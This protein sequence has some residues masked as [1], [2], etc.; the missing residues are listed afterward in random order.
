MQLPLEYLQSYVHLY[1][2][3]PIESHL[4]PNMLEKKSLMWIPIKFLIKTKCGQYISSLF[5]LPLESFLILTQFYFI[6][7]AFY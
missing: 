5:P 2:C 7:Q 6:S 4:D 1:L 3:F